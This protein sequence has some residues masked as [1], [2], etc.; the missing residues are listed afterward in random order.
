LNI[1]VRIS[2]HAGT[3]VC[4]HVFYLARHKVEQLGIPAKCG[5]IHIPQISGEMHLVRSDSLRLNVS[6]VLKGI[7]S[8]IKVLQED[9]AL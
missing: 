3:F 4:N 8:C 1:P 9:S 2:N 6:Q 7:K 5:L